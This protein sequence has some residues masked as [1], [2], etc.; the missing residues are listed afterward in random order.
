MKKILCCAAIA[1]FLSSCAVSE[2]R[3]QLAV[4]AVTGGLAGAFVGWQAFGPGGE[5]IL[6]ALAIGGASAGFGY[7]MADT[8]IP[9]E[10]ESFQKAAYQSLQATPDGQPTQWSSGDAAARASITPMRSFRD[11]AGRMCREF[12]VVYTIGKSRDSMKRTA[13]RGADGSWQTI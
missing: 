9:R 7:L 11:K 2:R 4:A 3:N 12:V 6:G 10:R 13:C 8:L 1:F 5:G